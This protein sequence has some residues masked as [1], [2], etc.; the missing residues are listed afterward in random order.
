LVLLAGTPELYQVN[1]AALLGSGCESLLAAKMLVDLEDGSKQEVV[2]M[3]VVDS[4][5]RGAELDLVLTKR[6]A[7]AFGPQAV[8]RARW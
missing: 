7:E 5:C 4:G 1:S 6:K 8:C 2:G 3:F